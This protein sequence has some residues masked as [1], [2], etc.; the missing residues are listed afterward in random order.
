MLWIRVRKKSFRIRADPKPKWFK[1]M[2]NFF[3][4]LNSFI[5]KSPKKPI[6]RRNRQPNKDLQEADIKKKV[7]SVPKIPGKFHVGSQ[8]ICEVGQIRIRKNINPDPQHCCKGLQWRCDD[9]DGSPFSRL[10]LWLEDSPQDSPCDGH[11]CSKAPGPQDSP[12][13]GHD[14]PN[15]L[16]PVATQNLAVTIL[17]WYSW[18]Y[19]Q[20]SVYNVVF[21]LYGIIFEKPDLS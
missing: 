3:K 12:C 20:R 17:Y 21:V 1:K 8:S 18:I 13:D 7:K 6:S 16:R 10:T 2:L 15:T 5:K 14:G 4:N 9:Q 11:D 19:D